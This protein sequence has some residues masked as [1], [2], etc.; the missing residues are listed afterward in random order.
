MLILVL[1]SNVDKSMLA[2]FP[3]PVKT[4]FSTPVISGLLNNAFL[5]TKEIHEIL[6]NLY[7]ESDSLTKSYAPFVSS[8]SV[9]IS[10]L[11]FDVIFSEEVEVDVSPLRNSAAD[12]IKFNGLK[13]Y[14]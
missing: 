11:I 6:L 14:L 13:K 5:Y 12:G 9:F 4:S 1:S 8:Y 10:P 7:T 2:L 3:E